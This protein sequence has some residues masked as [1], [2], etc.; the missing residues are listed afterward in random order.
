MVAVVGTWGCLVV[1]GWTLVYWPHV[2]EGFLYGMGLRPSQRTDLFDALYLSL[3]TVATLGFGDIV[4]VEGWLRVAVPL[5]AVVGFALLTAAV[6]W[7]LQIYP[8]LTRRRALALRLSLLRRA[9]TANALLRLDSAMAA[10]LLDSLAAEVVGVRIDLSQ[11]A[12]TYYF[13]DSAPDVSLAAMAGYAAQLAECGQAS[14]RE[15]V[16]LA[17]AVLDEALDDLTSLLD[18][19][20]L[21]TGGTAAEI[22]DAYAAD[23]EHSS[24]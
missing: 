4:P 21:R 6:S 16:R 15:D 13:R 12:E 11:Y 18:K 9:D 3:V 7:V 19:Q 1:V 17:A 14:A 24:K 2:P 23:H 8:A 10:L 5:Q 20:F 22:L